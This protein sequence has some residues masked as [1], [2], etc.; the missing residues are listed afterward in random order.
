MGTLVHPLFL[1]GESRM[2]LSYR[3]Q[4]KTWGYI[5]VLPA[6]LGFFLFMAYPM[7]EGI[8]LSLLEWSGLGPSKWIGLANYLKLFQ[9][10][11]FHKAVWNTAYYTLGILLIGVP[12]ALIL[13][14]ALNQK[15]RG[16][17]FYRMAY[18]LPVISMMVAVSMLWK[19]LLSTNH[20]LVNY[21][22]SF[23]GIPRINWLL[24]PKCAMP[25]LILM[26]IWKG[27]GFNMVVFLAGLQGIS[28]TYYEAADID[29]ATWWHKFRHI[30]LPL[31]S[32]TTFFVIITTTIHSFQIFQ[33]AYILTEGGPQGAT[34]TIVYYVYK[35]AFEWFKMGY[36]C[37]QASLLFVV[38]IV[39]TLIQLKL[40]KRWVHYA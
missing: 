5:F 1:K 22:L 12:L 6:M 15:L 11:H 28:S 9:D 30:T 16:R 13:A 35:N 38:L 23:V 10:R 21:F 24:D 40:Q 32:P 2:S 26:S 14:I 3:Q 18:Y 17:N 8:R 39:V 33:Q 31:L 20:G 37:S 34:T 25:G 19:W 29:G 36:A 27:T 4:E 7:V